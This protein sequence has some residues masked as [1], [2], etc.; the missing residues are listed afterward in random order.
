MS[1]PWDKIA[2]IIC[3]LGIATTLQGEQLNQ[4]LERNNNPIELP[5]WFREAKFGIYVQ[6]GPYSVPAWAPKGAFAQQYQLGLIQ[7]TLDGIGNFDPQAIFN[8]HVLKYGPDKNYYDFGYDFTAS[9]YDPKEWI[10]LFESSGAKY[11]ILC[12]KYADGYCL[13][14]SEYSESRGFRWNSQDVGPNRDLISDF[15]SAIKPSSLKFGLAYSLSE[16]FHP[17]WTKDREQY[18][19]EYLHPQIKE[20]ISTYEPDLF[21]AQDDDKLNPEIWRSNYLMNWITEHTNSETIFNDRWGIGT[22]MH[23][24]GYFTT[25]FG[26][27]MEMPKKHWE[28]HRPMGYSMGLNTNEDINEY[29]TLQELLLNLIHTVSLGGNLL[30]TVAPDDDGNIPPIQQERLLQIGQWL[31][32]YGEAIYQTESWKIP[33]QQ[34]EGNPVDLPI[35]EYIPNDMI[36]DITTNNPLGAA[37]VQ[38]YFTYSGKNLFAFI[39]NYKDGSLWMPG[40]D[41][42]DSTVITLMN[43]DQDIVWEDTG[44]DIKL[45]LPAYELSEIDPVAI[46]KISNIMGYVRKPELIIEYNSKLPTKVTIE[47][48]D[49][50]AMIFYTLD[51]TEPDATSKLYK[52]PFIIKKTTNLNVRAF[53]EGKTPSPIISRKVNPIASL[54]KV[55]LESEPTPPRKGYSS[56]LLIDQK[57]G[58]DRVESDQWMG[59]KNKDAE[60]VIDLGERKKIRKIKIGYMHKPGESIYAPSEVN[61][62]VSDDMFNYKGFKELN[63]I[64]KHA[65]YSTSIDTYET[66]IYNTQARYI[67]IHAKNA[68]RSNNSWLLIDEVEIE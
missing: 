26:L 28:N 48:R 51:G 20:L 55:I 47:S 21:Y 6:W 3:L 44:D 39:P 46:L 13:W 25:D 22:R 62:E 35:G 16:W 12:A 7:K 43:N 54:A 38:I 18:I 41:P 50:D 33:F 52:R 10:T 64:G 9:E 1:S 31:S 67:Y 8:Y 32:M 61:I 65:E 66:P 14:P 59:F 19:L 15:H 30:L 56:M 58:P 29:S 34:Y 53:V 2:I 42:S 5:D 68:L 24:G 45:E 37:G 4:S 23:D 60:L 11:V 57:R 27:P 17:L 63:K 49:D 36:L 40:I